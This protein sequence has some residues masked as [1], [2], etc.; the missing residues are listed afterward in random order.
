MYN[1]TRNSDRMDRLVLGAFGAHLED[2]LVELL[3]F[4]RQHGSFLLQWL[5]S[6]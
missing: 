1:T 3:A 5:I 4:A 6:V 2:G